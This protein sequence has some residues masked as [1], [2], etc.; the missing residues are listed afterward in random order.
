LIRPVILSLVIV[1]FDTFFL[2]KHHITYLHNGY[3][4]QTAI[5]L[6]C[7]NWICWW[8]LL[9]LCFFR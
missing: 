9:N 5:V 3:R 6:F 7:K 2:L 8:L 4:L 1:L